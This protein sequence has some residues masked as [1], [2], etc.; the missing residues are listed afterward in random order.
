[1]CVADRPRPEGPRPGHQPDLGAHR[2]SRPTTP[3]SWPSSGPLSGVEPQVERGSR[4]AGR[5]RTTRRC[6]VVA[7]EPSAPVPVCPHRR[8][9]EPR[10]AGPG[11]RRPDSPGGAPTGGWRS[12]EGLTSNRRAFYRSVPCPLASGSPSRNRTQPSEVTDDCRATARA[13]RT[14]TKRARRASGDRPGDVARHQ[15][16]EQEGRHHRPDPACRRSV[17]AVGANGDEPNGTAR[18]GSA[19]PGSDRLPG[20]IR[21]DQAPSTATPTDAATGRHGRGAWRPERPR[22]RAP[23]A[24]STP[25]ARPQRLDRIDGRRQVRVPAAGRRDVRSDADGPGRRRIAAAGAER[26]DGGDGGDRAAP[27]RCRR[28]RVAVRVRASSQ[29]RQQDRPAGTHSPATAGS[30]SPTPATGVAAGAAAA[31][32]AASASCRAGGQEA[33]YSGELVPVR[34]LLDL[35][36]EGYGFLRADGYL[37]SSQGRLHLDQPGAPVRPAP[38][39]LRRGCLPPGGVNEKFPALIR[40][41]SVSGLAPDEARR[42]AAVRGP[43]AAVPRREAPPRDAR[44]RRR[45]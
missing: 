2:R 22:R 4:P 1:M 30:S 29:H 37:P 45:T 40:I 19:G 15:L 26:S 10:G 31:S 28:P 12:C 9:R 11:F 24:R 42:P 43:H 20:A 3:R 21:T 16:A 41:D 39:R 23:Q 14:R 34:G 8:S 13:V 18:C 32:V 38:G 25:T 17:R 6:G 36:D 33:Q 7:Y 35:R 5:E 44:R 27:S